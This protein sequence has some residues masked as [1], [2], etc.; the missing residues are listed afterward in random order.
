[1]NDVLSTKTGYLCSPDANVYDIDFTRFRIRDTES[2]RVL[3]E[4]T[5]PPGQALPSFTTAS[6]EDSSL[7]PSSKTHSRNRSKDKRKEV[8]GGKKSR[9]E[10]GR[11]LRED[12]DDDEDDE[13][14]GEEDDDE[15]EED[16]NE[17]TLEDSNS[18]RFVRYQ[19]PSEF[20]QLKTV[21]ATIDFSVGSKPISKFRMIERHF[22]RDTLLK[23]FDFEFGFCIPNSS[24]SC[25]HIYEFPSLTNQMS[26]CRFV[27]NEC[28]LIF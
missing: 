20:L 15:R 24:N 4:V 12:G 16:D 7:N 17:M 2:S 14:Q 25:E 9:E 11:D 22:F 10:Q 27:S 6:G 13:E 3:F 5:K 23:T 18:C 28:T 19:F 21:G 8:A 26:K 1:M